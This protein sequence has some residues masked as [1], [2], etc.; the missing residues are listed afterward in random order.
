MIFSTVDS[1]LT[2]PILLNT[3]RSLTVNSTVEL[4]GITIGLILRDMATSG[5]ISSLTEKVYKQRE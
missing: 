2:Y 1:Y 3:S 5:V 4:R